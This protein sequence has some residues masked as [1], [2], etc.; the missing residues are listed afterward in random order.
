VDFEENHLSGYLELF[1]WLRAHLT[2]H[3]E[4]GL[5]GP[6][7]RWLGEALTEMRDLARRP[8]PP[9]PCRTFLG[10]R[11]A[12]VDPDAIRTRM[13]GWADGRLTEFPQCQHE[14]MME[15][16]EVRAQV[17]DDLAAHFTPRPPQSM[18]C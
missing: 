14:L 8:A 7:L 11:E 2:A 16:P 3:P 13:A 5:G 15:T 18:A 17:F 1:D 4:M 6:S 10:G 12:I 9:V